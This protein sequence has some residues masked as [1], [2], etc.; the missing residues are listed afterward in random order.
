[1]IAQTR[2]TRRLSLVT[3]EHLDRAKERIDLD[4]ISRENALAAFEIKKRDRQNLAILVASH[5]IVALATA[6]L[7]LSTV[8]LYLS[9]LRDIL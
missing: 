4:K 8:W 5:L 1:M 3:A 2:E 6:A 7:T 9:D